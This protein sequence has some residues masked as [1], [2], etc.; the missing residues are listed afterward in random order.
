[1]IRMNVLILGGRPIR[2]GEQNYHNDKIFSEYKTANISSDRK[3]CSY[4]QLKSLQWSSARQKS[5]QTDFLMNLTHQTGTQSAEIAAG[6]GK[7]ITPAFPWIFP[8]SW[9]IAPSGA[10]SHAGR[11]SLPLLLG[12]ALVNQPPQVLHDGRWLRVDHLPVASFYVN[13]IG[14]RVGRLQKLLLKCSYHL[15]QVGGKTG[16]LWVSTQ[17]QTTAPGCRLLTWL[18][19][20][21]ISWSKRS[22]VITVTVVLLER[23]LNLVIS[24]EGNGWKWFLEPSI[25]L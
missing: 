3:P 4:F 6:K 2:N 17:A 9:L 11:G 25:H 15:A 14:W 8:P 24:L 7:A 22:P 23:G 21:D 13:V 1:M 19:W 5:V 12:L 18:S 10:L 20:S 16:L